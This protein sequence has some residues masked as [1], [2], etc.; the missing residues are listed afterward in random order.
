MS[1]DNMRKF[2]GMLATRNAECAQGRR[3]EENGGSDLSG[4]KCKRDRQ[5][6]EY[7]NESESKTYLGSSNVDVRRT[8]PTPVCVRRRV[9]NFAGRLGQSGRCER[10]DHCHIASMSVTAPS[11]CPT[12]TYAQ[13]R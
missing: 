10:R 5:G 4:S 3:V 9:R 11:E 12:T 2:A 6:G 8:L 1:I 13:R 7:P